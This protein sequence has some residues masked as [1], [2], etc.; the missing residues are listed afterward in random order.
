M[1]EKTVLS[2]FAVVVVDRGFVYV[3]DVVCDG[4]WCAITG[5]YNIRTW[6]TTKGLGELVLHGP[7][8]KTVLDEVGALRVPYHAVISIID[9]EKGKWKL[10]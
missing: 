3:G 4:E 2:G 6:G 7:T 1:Q 5:A 10:S 9:S 8:E